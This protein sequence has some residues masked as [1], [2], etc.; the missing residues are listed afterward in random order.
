MGM[1]AQPIYNKEYFLPN[2]LEFEVIEKF[3][4]AVR[5]PDAVKPDINFWVHERYLVADDSYLMPCYGFK[6]C[7]S[8]EVAQASVTMDGDLPPWELWRP[9][10][11]GQREPLGLRVPHSVW[12]GYR[13]VHEDP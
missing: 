13:R 10:A 12:A 4:A 8:F 9:P 2:E 11:L 6:V 3:V 1:G 5:A 7:S